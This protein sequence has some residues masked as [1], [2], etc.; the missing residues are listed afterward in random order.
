MRELYAKRGA[1]GPA[2]RAGLA[3]EEVRARAERQVPQHVRQRRRGLVDDER[4][5]RQQR[6]QHAHEVLRRDRHA[7]GARVGG[8]GEASNVLVAP[9]SQRHQALAGRAA[10]GVVLALG[11]RL[12]E[13]AQRAAHAGHDAERDGI[14]AA[15]LPRV[16][17]DLDDRL[18]CA[19][20]RT[21]RVEEP[22]EDVRADDEDHVEAL[23]RL[24]GGGRR[25][26]QAAAPQRMITGEGQP[27][28][29]GLAVHRSAERLGE[30]DELGLGAGARDAIAADD[31]R[32]LRPRQQRPRASDR[33]GL[34]RRSQ[35]DGPTGGA[36]VIAG[37]VHEIHRQR[38][39]DGPRR[40][41]KRQVDRPTQRARRLGRVAEL[42]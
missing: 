8:R 42:V 12:V 19:E 27:S 15:D 18:G 14:A 10:R 23:Q 41:R 36:A 3:A 30:R 33:L 32:R 24:G 37:L 21:R 11:H 34:R 40:R 7:L 20:R 1:H 9:A 13:V 31:R 25:R 5:R 6:A 35:R 28:M 17:V 22:R 38:E 26:I 2:E 29:D 16:V 39:E 4:V